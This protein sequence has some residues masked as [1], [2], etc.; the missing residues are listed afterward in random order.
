MARLQGVYKL[1]NGS[2]PKGGTIKLRVP[3]DRNT[4]NG[5][6]Y[7]LPA[8]TIAIPIDATTGAYDSGTIPDGPYQ[9]RRVITG[10]P[11]QG[12]NGGWSDVILSG[13]TDLQTAI[14]TYDPTSYTP[15]VVS[16]AQAAAAS[17]AASAAAAAS[18]AA[19]A[20]SYDGGVDE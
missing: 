6:S 4:T 17:A 20:A 14:D 19:S 18:S 2:I 9:V 8:K 15:P 12:S 16:A 11:P 10:A 3:R 5:S 7:T 13:T 1:P